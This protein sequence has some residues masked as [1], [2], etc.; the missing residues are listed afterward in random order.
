MGL[1][2]K[3]VTVLLLTK[4]LVGISNRESNMLPQIFYS[5][6]LQCLVLTSLDGLC[7]VYKIE[8]D[9]VKSSVL[10][11]TSKTDKKVDSEAS[12]AILAGGFSSSGKYFVLCNDYKQVLLYE[13]TQGI[14]NS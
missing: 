1:I 5:S 3:P 12:G 11:L 6:S 7:A 2:W 10:D 14:Q 13:T 8:K 9:S 4:D